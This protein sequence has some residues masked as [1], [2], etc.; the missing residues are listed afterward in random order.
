MTVGPE[1]STSPTR[2]AGTGAPASVTRTATPTGT[3]TDPGRRASSGFAQIWLAASV[4][5]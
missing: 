3:P 2:P 1:I 5:P 4:I